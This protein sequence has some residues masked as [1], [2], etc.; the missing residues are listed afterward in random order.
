MSARLPMNGTPKRT[1]SSSEKPTTSMLKGSGR[2]SD[3]FDERQPE[4]DAENAVERAGARHRVEMRADE[5]RGVSPDAARPPS[6]QISGG[7]DADVHAETRP[8]TREG[9]RGRSCIGGDRNVRVVNPGSSVK[10]ASARHRR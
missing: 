7:V 5:E 3:E 10:A 4:N 1:P 2:R 8:S 6:A 9:A